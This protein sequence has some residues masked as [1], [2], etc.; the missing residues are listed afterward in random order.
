MKRYLLPALL[1]S[2]LVYPQVYRAEGPLAHTYSI[3]A[4]DEATGDMGVA[5][6]SH[7]FSVG[8]AVSWGEAGV[9]VVATQ[10]FTNVSFGI[11]GLAMLKA[12][13]SPQE[14]LDSLLSDDEGRDYR[15]V[16]ILDTKGRAAAHTG[17]KCIADAGHLAGENYSVQANLMLNDKVWPAMEKAF[18]EAK[19][20]LAERMLAALQL[21]CR[22]PRLQAVI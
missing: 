19:G 20:T 2:S 14:V 8:T 3:V 9:G 10:S 18:K 22:L 21:H 15:Q 17:S 13:L 7:W 12:G 5:V 6:Q 4:R 11:R 1:L 16:A